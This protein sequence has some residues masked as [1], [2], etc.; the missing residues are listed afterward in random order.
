VPGVTGFMYTTWQ[1]RY[2]HLEAYGRA[3]MGKE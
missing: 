2:D 1:N 3:M